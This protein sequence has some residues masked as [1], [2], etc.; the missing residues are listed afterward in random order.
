MRSLKKNKQKN[1][2]W[3]PDDNNKA[4][5]SYVGTFYVFRSE[6]LRAL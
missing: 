3:N 6:T 2:S 4:D 1:N 5:Y